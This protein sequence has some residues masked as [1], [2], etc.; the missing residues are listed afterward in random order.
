MERIAGEVDRIAQ[1]C[2][3]IVAKDVNSDSVGAYVLKRRLSEVNF[4]VESLQVPSHEAICHEAFALRINRGRTSTPLQEAMPGCTSMFASLTEELERLDIAPEENL[5][6]LEAVLLTLQPDG[7]DERLCSALG[8]LMSAL[9][10]RSTPPARQLGVQA[11]REAT[12]ALQPTTHTHEAH[13]VTEYEPEWYQDVTEVHVSLG[14]AAGTSTQDLEVDIS[15]DSLRIFH[16]LHQAALLEG[17]LCGC[18]VPASSYWVID[19]GRGGPTLQVML[20]K[21][22]GSPHWFSLLEDGRFAKSHRQVTVKH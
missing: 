1:L 5:R 13:S 14:L 4:H 12:S 21:E 16:K 18:V 3:H 22:P 6:K 15:R 19:S 20:A 7:S 2:P 17:R 11:P 8:G 9:R 10:A